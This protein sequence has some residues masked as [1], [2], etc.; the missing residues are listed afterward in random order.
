MKVG[1]NEAS[2]VE[3]GSEFSRGFHICCVPDCRGSHSSHG[4]V[5]GAWHEGIRD[6]EVEERSAACRMS[7]NIAAI[8]KSFEKSARSRSKNLEETLPLTQAAA[9]LALRVAATRPEEAGGRSNFLELCGGTYRVSRCF[10]SK[11]QDALGVN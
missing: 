5:I 3:V 10:E 6:V 2:S 8:P 9:G 4:A 7:D 11:G 1:C